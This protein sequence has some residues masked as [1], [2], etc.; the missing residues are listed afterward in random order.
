M[1][2]NPNDDQSGRRI[3]RVYYDES[4]KKNDSFH[5]DDDNVK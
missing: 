1:K 5:V 2:I 4:E 3:I